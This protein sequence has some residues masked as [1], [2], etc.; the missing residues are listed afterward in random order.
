MS[1]IL[2]FLNGFVFL[3]DGFEILDPVVYSI[4]SKMTKF[5][6]LGMVI[7]KRFLNHKT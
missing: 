7:I 5:L 6:D 2:T 4:T 1:V 3:T